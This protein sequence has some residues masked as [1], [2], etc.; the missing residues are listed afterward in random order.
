VVKQ[1][2]V[3]QFICYRAAH[4]N[5][6]CYDSFQNEM[7]QSTNVSLD[8]H[9]TSLF[10]M[11][12]TAVKT[13]TRS[14]LYQ[15][16]HILGVCFAAMTAPPPYA[17]G[18]HHSRHLS[19][20]QCRSALMPMKYCHCKFFDQV[21]RNRQGR[22]QG[23]CLAVMTGPFV[24]QVGYSALK[25]MVKY[26]TLSLQVYNAGVLEQATAYISLLTLHSTIMKQQRPFLV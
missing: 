1:E 14:D 19:I 20:E 22:I 7:Y 4:S 10:Q 9:W 18:T 16:G 21:V 11:E 12:C 2:L 25:P 17:I 6:K 8:Q 15:K 13:N 3:L 23:V 24:P 26:Q 5:L